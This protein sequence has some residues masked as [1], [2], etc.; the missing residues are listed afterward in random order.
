MV[1]SAAASRTAGSARR[2]WP[3]LWR[4]RRRGECGRPNARPSRPSARC[5]VPRVPVK[6]HAKAF[7]GGNVRRSLAAQN[8]H[9]F[10]IA[11]PRPGLEGVGNVRLNGVTGG[12]LP[13]GQ[14]GADAALGE[15]RVA[16]GQRTLAQQ[17]HAQP[18]LG[19]EQ[20][21]VEAGDAAAHHHQVR[22][23]RCS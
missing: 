2:Q 7:Q 14:D 9:G 11:L 21:T 23:A 15:V 13:R 18:G 3:P 16:L 6:H 12:C 19:G 20:C 17:R 4:P 8:A 1:P 10:R 5:P 22:V